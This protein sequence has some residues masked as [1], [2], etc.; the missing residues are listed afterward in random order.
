[1][2][3][4]NYLFTSQLEIF[5]VK[6]NYKLKKMQLDINLCQNQKIQSQQ[7]AQLQQ[8]QHLKPLDMFKIITLYFFL[9]THYE[10]K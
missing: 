10:L 5:I 8:T 1:M 7:Q 9:I 6:I 3:T 4:Q 2:M